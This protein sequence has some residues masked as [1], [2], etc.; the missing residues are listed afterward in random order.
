MENNLNNHGC[1]FIIINNDL[2]RKLCSILTKFVF[3]DNFRKK[4]MSFE[5]IYFLLWIWLFLSNLINCNFLSRIYIQKKLFWLC[6]FLGFK[7]VPIIYKAG[8]LLISEIS[9]ICHIWNKKFDISL[10]MPFVFRISNQN[11]IDSSIF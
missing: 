1:I 9:K 7:H 5:S 6:F 2:R 3:T 4:S 11:S 8:F 10:Y